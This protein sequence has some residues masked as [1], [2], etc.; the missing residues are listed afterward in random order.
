MKGQVSN[1]ILN[2]IQVSSD[3]LKKAYNKYKS[4]WEAKQ[5]EI[6]I[7][8]HGVIL[9]VYCRMMRGFVRSMIRTLRNREKGKGQ[10]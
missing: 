6:F 10:L 9:K 2:L 5:N 7:M 8:E 4:D 1:V 3:R